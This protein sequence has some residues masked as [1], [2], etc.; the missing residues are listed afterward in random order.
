MKTKVYPTGGLVYQRW[1]GR[2]RQDIINGTK[3]F[4]FMFLDY[5]ET[6]SKSWAQAAVLGR[7][8]KFINVGVYVGDELLLF[9]KQSEEQFVS[10]LEKYGYLHG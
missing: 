8:G 5:N 3:K 6:V 1:D 10:I 9:M 4:P 2:C 7:G